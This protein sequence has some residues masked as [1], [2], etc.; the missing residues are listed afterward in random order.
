MQTVNC[1][2]LRVP[3]KV[4]VLVKWR[5]GQLTG[6]EGRFCMEVQIV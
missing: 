3:I 4:F 6:N 2:G 1:L 5:G